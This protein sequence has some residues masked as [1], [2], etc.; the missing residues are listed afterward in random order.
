MNDMLSK[1]PEEES[2][3]FPPIGKGGV[4]QSMVNLSNDIQIQPKER[5][6]KKAIA[7]KTIK[8]E[9]IIEDDDKEKNE[10]K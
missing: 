6:V 5:Q 8:N 3:R 2:T 4:S 10:K 7:K 9:I 1:N